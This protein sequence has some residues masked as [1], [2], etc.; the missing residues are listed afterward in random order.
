[1]YK[2]IRQI[3]GFRHVK[4]QNIDRRIKILHQQHWLTINGTK[5]AKAH[6]LQPLYQLSVRAE[7]ALELNKK[8]LNNL[9]QTASEEQLRKLIEA[10]KM[11]S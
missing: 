6:F 7:A 10:L 3:K 4:R 9:L 8:D 2:E 11:Y 1:M 5:P